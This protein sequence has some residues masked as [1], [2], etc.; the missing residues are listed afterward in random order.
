MKCI[1]LIN[2]IKNGEVGSIIRVTDVEADTRVSSG[3]WKF[4]SKSEYKNYNRPVA[5]ADDESVEKPKKFK[6]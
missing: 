5:V 4:V 1:K 3:N 2:S 6:K